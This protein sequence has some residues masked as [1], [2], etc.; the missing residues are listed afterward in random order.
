MAVGQLLHSLALGAVESRACWLLPSLLSVLQVAIRLQDE[1]GVDTTLEP[2]GFSVA[3]WVLGG[4]PAVERA[5][6]MFNTTVVR[7][8]FA[9]PVLLFRNEFAFNQ[10]I[11]EQGEKLGELSAF[12]QP[13][14]N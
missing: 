7:D 11:A 10:V 3:R 14:D 9:R 1:Y 5:G 8:A 13:P 2:L 12:A 6:R 4:W